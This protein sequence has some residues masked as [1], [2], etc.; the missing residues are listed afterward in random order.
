MIAIVDYGAGNLRSIKRALETVGADAVITT[1]PAIIAAADA[2]VFPGVGHAGAAMERLHGLGLPP[3]LQETI[4]AGKPFLGICLGMQLLFA[5]QDEGDVE[6]L[7]LLPGRVRRLS[8]PIKVPHMGWNRS[9]LVHDGPLGA[10]GNER[11][12]YFVH[13]YAVEPAVPADIAAEASYGHS[14]PSIII[15]DNIW[16]TQFHPEKSGA[17]GLEVLRAF[18]GRIPGAVNRRRLPSRVPSGHRPGMNSRAGR[19]GVSAIDQR[20]DP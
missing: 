11:Y 20:L 3:V 16:G 19:G 9:R 15:H 12:Y 7:G 5:H 1:D 6:G 18:V 4:A 13:S 2:I 17:A 8:G 10:T 14:F